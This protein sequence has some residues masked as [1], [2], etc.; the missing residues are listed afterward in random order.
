MGKTQRRLPGRTEREQRLH[1]RQRT[2]GANPNLSREGLKASLDRNILESRK[3][4]K[5]APTFSPL[6]GVPG[7]DKALTQQNLR[8]SQEME[9]PGARKGVGAK[10]GCKQ[11]G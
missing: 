2:G 10:G 8:Q 9:A 7:E 11:E 5:E 4:I 3:Q 6:S 1:T